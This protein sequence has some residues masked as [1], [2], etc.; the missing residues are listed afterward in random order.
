MAMIKLLTAE[1]LGIIFDSILSKE[2]IITFYDNKY[3]KLNLND[4]T[5]KFIITNN[6]LI[7]I[8]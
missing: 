4:K 8:E 3:L 1:S 7:I 2:T 6:F 5:F